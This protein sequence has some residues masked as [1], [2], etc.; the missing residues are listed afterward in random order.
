VRILRAVALLF[1][2]IATAVAQ[3]AIPLSLEARSENWAP[4][5]VV[6]DFKEAIAETAMCGYESA[7]SGEPAK[8]VHVD[9]N[10]NG[11]EVTLAVGQVMELSLH[12]NPTTGFR[13]DLKTKAE[14]ACEL[15]ESTFNPPGGP[16]G[17]GGMHRWQFRAVQSGSG[18]IEREYRR[19]WEKDAAPAKV[20][21]LSVRVRGPG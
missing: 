10:D 2:C 13:W 18:E 12:E 3:D 1:F 11:H 5:S 16:P 6:Y 17:N 8:M 15:V 14:P 9:Q 19:P 21:K 7:D 4:K 20:Y